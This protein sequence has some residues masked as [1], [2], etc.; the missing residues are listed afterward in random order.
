MHV[1]WAVLMKLISYLHSYLIWEFYTTAIDELLLTTILGVAA[2]TG[3]AFLLIPHWTA[4]PIVAVSLMMLYVEL[5]G[6]HR[7]LYECGIARLFIT[8]TSTK[9]LLLHMSRCFTSCWGIHQRSQLHCHGHVYWT[10]S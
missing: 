4:A 9:S 6:K 8:M 10:A 3:I 7:S 5:L 2:V 1:Y